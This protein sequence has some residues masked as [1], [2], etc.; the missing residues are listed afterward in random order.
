M[1]TQGYGMH[2]F[3]KRKRIHLKKEEFP[4]KN[5]KVRFLDGLIYVVSVIGPLMTLPQ[6][7][8]IWVLK[9]AEGV[10]F[11]S[12]G[13]YTISAGIWL[14]YGIVHKDKPIIIAN[15]LWII[16]HLMVV[17]GILVYGKNLL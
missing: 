7:F 16:I 1:V 8:K 15:I 11:I 9:N 10:S 12:W 6:I 14:W 17:I 4:S 5:K 13:T 3:H 2:H